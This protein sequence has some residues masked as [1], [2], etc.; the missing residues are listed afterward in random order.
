MND[1]YTKDDEKKLPEVNI[2][3]TATHRRSLT[4]RYRYPKVS[5]DIYPLLK[6]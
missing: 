3:E 1:Y 5:D 2:Y 4:D 6:E